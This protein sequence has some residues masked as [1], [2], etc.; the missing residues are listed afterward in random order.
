MERLADGMI[1]ASAQNAAAFATQKDTFHK[2]LRAYVMIQ[3]HGLALQDRAANIKLE[4]RTTLLNAGNTPAH[5]VNF[6]SRLIILPAKVPEDF[7]F[8]L[9]QGDFDAGAM[10]FPHQTLTYRAW[11]PDLISDEELAALKR[12]GERT[13]YVYGV[14]RYKDIFSEEHYTN[15]CQFFVWDIAGNYSTVNVL[16][17]NEY[18]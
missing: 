16:R 4:A 3:G 17:H 7:D 12:I 14:V 15:F 6:S 18:T 13:L 2:Q 1:A 8:D 5:S 9:P 11:L 10:L